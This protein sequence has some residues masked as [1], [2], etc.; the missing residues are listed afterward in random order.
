VKTAETNTNGSESQHIQNKS[1]QTVMQFPSM[2]NS[3]PNSST[4]LTNE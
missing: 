4:R 2:W 3:S 1:P